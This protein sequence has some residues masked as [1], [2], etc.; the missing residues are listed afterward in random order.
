MVDTVTPVE[1]L[2]AGAPVARAAKVTVY[3]V[4]L[5]N[6]APETTAVN[7]P[8]A[9]MAPLAAKATVL[10]VGPVTANVAVP[11]VN[12][13]GG[14]ENVIRL[15]AA[16]GKSVATVNLMV[17]AT[18]VVACAAVFGFWAT[19]NAPVVGMVTRPPIAWMAT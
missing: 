1:K 5:S 2:A 10:P 6:V 19:T 13:V 7:T 4:A 17:A 15:V 16:A 18:T 11:L 9:E 8:A 14:K 3:S 12:K